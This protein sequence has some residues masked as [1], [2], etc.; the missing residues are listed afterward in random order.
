AA[1]ADRTVKMWDAPKGQEVFTLKG[2]HSSVLCVTFS[3]DGT[4]ILSGCIDSTAKLWD[5]RKGREVFTLKG[6][7]GV[8]L[9]VAFSPDG[10]RLRLRAGREYQDFDT[11][12]G[13]SLPPDDA[14][15]PPPGKQLQARQP[16]G[17]LV[18]IANGTNIIVRRPGAVEAGMDLRVLNRS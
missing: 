11:V 18:A 15:L 5:A 3:R 1:C 13:K 6:L 14:P 4:H 10:K 9:G 12:T 16:G 17:H 8:V 2:H 7:P